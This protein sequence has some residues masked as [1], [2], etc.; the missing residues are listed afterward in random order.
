TMTSIFGRMATYSGQM[1]KWDDAI[2][3]ELALADVDNLKSMDNEAPV[4][5][6]DDGTYPCPI[7]GE[8]K[9]I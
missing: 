8:S 1:V 9:V 3:S 6:N 4:K 7:P 5:P 2:G